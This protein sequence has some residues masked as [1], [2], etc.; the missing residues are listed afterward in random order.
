[1]SSS[2]RRPV[3][4]ASLSHADLVELLAHA[5]DRDPVICNQADPPAYRVLRLSLHSGSCCFMLVATHEL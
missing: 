5:C 4:L 2:V 1:M 3:R